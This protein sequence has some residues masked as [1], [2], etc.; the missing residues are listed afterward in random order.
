M[1]LKN[2]KFRSA[3]GIC[4]RR[5]ECQGI[6]TKIIARTSFECLRVEVGLTM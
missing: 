1:T 5:L 6:T 2:V 4:K 3:A